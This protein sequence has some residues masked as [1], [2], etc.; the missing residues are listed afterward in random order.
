MMEK[1][2]F[3]VFLT[4]LVALVGGVIFLKWVLI[5]RDLPREGM[6]EK[7]LRI[8]SYSTFVSSSGP[9][10]ELVHE[11][12]KRCRC[13]VDFVTTGDAGLLLER[14][15]L[16]QDRAQYDVVIGLDRFW[17]AKAAQEWEWLEP[18][19][20]KEKKVEFV[21][22]L[23]I[24]D[25]A[26][27]VPF[28]YAPMTFIYRKSDV[29]NVPQSLSDFLKPEFKSSISL[30]DPRSSSPGLQFFSWVILTQGEEAEEFLKK[31]KPPFIV[32]HHLGP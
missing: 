28:D 5:G 25:L 11:F 2:R 30:Q 8:L 15:K 16:T 29:S 9:A 20:I 24:E 31:F 19:L 26:Q 27:F 32:F 22:G 17:A 7:E 23:A 12:K 10:P 3:V 14:L 18:V 4:G 13:K 6:V 21:E 1:G